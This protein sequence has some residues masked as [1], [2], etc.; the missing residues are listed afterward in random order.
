MLSSEAVAPTGFIPCLGTW[1]NTQMTTGKSL[2][3]SEA[4]TTRVQPLIAVV[5]DDPSFL[6]SVGR[7][8]HSANYAVETFGSAHDFLA[9]QQSS[10]PQC[11]VLDVHMP[12][13]TGLELHDRLRAQGCRLPIVFVTAYETPH[14]REHAHLPGVYGLLLKPFDKRILLNAVQEALKDRSQNPSAS[15]IQ[16]D[17]P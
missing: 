5:D 8:L 10:A 15:P 3:R 2:P 6:R 7:L 1:S 13:M 17:Q 4:A 9:A 12:G 16:P 14:T 11:L